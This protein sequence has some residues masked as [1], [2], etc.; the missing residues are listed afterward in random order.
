MPALPEYQRC[1]EPRLVEAIGAFVRTLGVRGF[2]RHILANG[3]ESS[4]V[5][6]YRTF[7]ERN[8]EIQIDRA[9]FDERIMDALKNTGAAFFAEGAGIP[10][11]MMGAAVAHGLGYSPDAAGACAFAGNMTANFLTYCT[12]WAVSHRQQF[13]REG[14]FDARGFIRALLKE[15]L[16][17]FGPI[18][19]G[20]DVMEAELIR[21]LSHLNVGYISSAGFIT[22]MGS[23]SAVIAYFYEQQARSHMRA[24]VDALFYETPKGNG[25]AARASRW[26]NAVMVRLPTLH[27][28]V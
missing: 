9:T 22:L 26:R 3:T 21:R 11:A 2:V 20:A 13:I 24:K 12:A 18:A 15:Y 28:P 25:L 4:R 7:R 1:P 19:V 5:A 14:G 8:P 23:I 16:E 27:F 10:G 6:L 17:H